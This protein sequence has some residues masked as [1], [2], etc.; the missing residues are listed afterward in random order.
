[1]YWWMSCLRSDTAE[2]TFSDCVSQ[3]TLPVEWPQSKE[4][5]SQA[6]V[7]IVDYGQILQ[8]ACNSNQSLWVV[9][10]IFAC[11]SAG[12]FL[13]RFSW[14]SRSTDLLSIMMERHCQRNILTLRILKF[15]R[16]CCIL[17]DW[18][19]GPRKD[20]VDSLWRACNYWQ[21]HLDLRQISIVWL[22]EPR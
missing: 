13:P 8:G 7:K 12:L 11:C 22:K 19:E 4:E 14:S 10:R 6:V 15:Y 17:T 16:P 9:C 21:K 2:V 3:S 18:H 20:S 1:M 5:S